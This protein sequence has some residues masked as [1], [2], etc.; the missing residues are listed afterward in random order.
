MAWRT[1]NP[2][3]LEQK[4]EGV[5]PLSSPLLSVPLTVDL[6][7]SIRRGLAAKTT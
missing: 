2:T 3:G 7:L 6:S 1:A 4:R 5:L